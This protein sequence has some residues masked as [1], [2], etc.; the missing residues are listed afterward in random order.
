QQGRLATTGRTDEG[1]H[2]IGDQ[3]QVDALQRMVLAIVE[4]EVAH[5]DLGPRFNL[6]GHG[7]YRDFRNTGGNRKLT[8]FE[9]LSAPR[10]RAPIFRASTV[11]VIIK[12]PL[13]A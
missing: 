5:A 7:R 11:R 4:V 1:G 10:M 12:A 6:S 8:H 9:V 13:Q 2:S 3:V